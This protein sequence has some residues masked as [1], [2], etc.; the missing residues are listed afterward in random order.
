MFEYSIVWLLAFVFGG[1]FLA[2]AIVQYLSR[3]A[4]TLPGDSGSEY[5]L[6]LYGKRGGIGGVPQPT[7]WSREYVYRE[8]TLAVPKHASSSR[9][10]RRSRKEKKR[11]RYEGDS[12]SEDEEDCYDMEER[13]GA[14]GN[15]GR[16]GG[17]IQDP[18]GDDVW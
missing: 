18:V 6:P 3:H 8:P 10:E 12:G 7:A 14:R 15:R 13:R 9:K 4:R 17:R 16:R 2:L 1:T 11:K 5:D